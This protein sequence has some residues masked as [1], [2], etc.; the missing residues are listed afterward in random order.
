MQYPFAAD[1]RY[2]PS[3]QEI[4][5]VAHLLRMMDLH[6][7]DRAVI[8][9]TN[10]GY[11]EDLAPVRDAL[12]RGEGRFRGVA[13]VAPDI[14][15]AA[16]ARL[17]AEGFVGVA[18]NA[19]FHPPAHYLGQDELLR[20]LEGEGLLLQLQIEHDQLLQFLPMI[21][22]CSVPLVIDHCGRPDPARG[23]DQP[24]FAAL[25]ALGRA[26]RATVKLSG[27]NKLSQERHPHADAQKF[28]SALIEAFTFERCVW[29]SDFPFLRAPERIDLAPLLALGEAC[30]PDP[31]DRHR[32]FWETPARVFGFD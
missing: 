11:G 14:S 6:G 23:P 32:L 17:R 1:T 21:E 30:A 4:A 26:G 15:T 7:I 10:S 13:V 12:A 29:G 2:R 25:L 9:G 3:G 31:V 24:G 16:L 22:R 18:F 28:V 19:T 20:R 5:P 8:V 27:I